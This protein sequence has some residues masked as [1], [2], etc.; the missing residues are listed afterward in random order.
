[1]DL[2]A[3]KRDRRVRG[4]C[5]PRAAM[6]DPMTLGDAAMLGFFGTVLTFCAM[7]SGEMERA[8]SIATAWAMVAMLALVALAVM[9]VTPWRA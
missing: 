4:C 5:D 3:G 6:V 8:R 1:M 7:M 9:W 2:V